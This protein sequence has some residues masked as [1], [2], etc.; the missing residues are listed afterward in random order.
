MDGPLQQH[1]LGNL[2]EKKLLRCHP[3]FTESETQNGLSILHFSKVILRHCE[4]R[5]T[6]LNCEQLAIILCYSQLYSLIN[7]NLIVF[8]TLPS[9]LL[10][11]KEFQAKTNPW[12]LKIKLF[13]WPLKRKNFLCTLLSDFFLPRQ[14]I[15]S[16]SVTEGNR[17][18][19]ANCQQDVW[20]LFVPML[21]MGPPAL[22]LGAKDTSSFLIPHSLSSSSLL[23]ST[24]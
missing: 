7:L 20:P 8:L 22:P 19:F 13:F 12:F 11:L 15:D 9:Q 6:C 5:A 14:Y 3:S 2:I 23:R 17:T 21:S 24:P 18:I 16:I 1:P 4:V 10:Y